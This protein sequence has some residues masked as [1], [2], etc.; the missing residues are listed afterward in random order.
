MREKVEQ[1]GRLNFLDVRSGSESQ[2]QPIL[3]GFGI[4]P[5]QNLSPRKF[6]LAGEF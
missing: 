2:H 1:A 3:V 5:A 4:K 6:P